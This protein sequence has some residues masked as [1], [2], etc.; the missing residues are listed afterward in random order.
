LLPLA[1]H[2]PRCENLAVG[3]TPGV[4]FS[5]IKRLHCGRL[6][7]YSFEI[8]TKDCSQSRASPRSLPIR[9]SRKQASP[10]PVN[11]PLADLEI[12]RHRVA[13]EK[14]IEGIGQNKIHSRLNGL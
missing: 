6:G 8:Y 11:R 1:N 2:G 9:P 10:E 3:N 5:Y 12:C 7:R 4:L 14:A 13:T